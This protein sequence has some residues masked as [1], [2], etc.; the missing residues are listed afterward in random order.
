MISELEERIRDR[1]HEIWERE[2]RPADKAEEHWRRATT[3]LAAAAPQKASAKPR[4]VK[5]AVAHKVERA[6]AKPKAE[7]KPKGARK[8]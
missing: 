7:A 5:A 3:E 2:G 8:V 4:A 6:A 1:A